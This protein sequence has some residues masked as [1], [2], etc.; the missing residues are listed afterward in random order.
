MQCLCFPLELFIKICVQMLI[1]VAPPKGWVYISIYL[2]ELQSGAIACTEVSISFCL[3]S[4]FVFPGRQSETRRTSAEFRRAELPCPGS[5]TCPFSWKLNSQMGARKLVLPLLSVASLLHIAATLRISAFNIQA[6]GD[7]KLSNE[8]AADIIINI[9]SRYDIALVQEVRDSDLSAVTKLMDQLNSMTMDAYSY[10]RS[11]PLGR[12]SYKE[13]Y[14][15]IYRKEVVSVVDRYQYEDPEDIFSR[16]PFIMKFSSP[17]LK[18][19]EFVLVPLHTCPH[20]AVTEID[21]LYDVYLDVIDK[22]ETDDIM[23]LGDFNADCS[24]VKEGDWEHI[25]LRTSE[26]FKWLIP[27]DADTT[28]G[29]SDCAYDRIV[30]CGS[31]LRKSI[32]PKSATVYNFQ[33]AFKLE[34]AEALAVS[35]H[36]PVELTLKTH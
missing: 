16:E 5:Q 24:Y 28:V 32:V 23:F 3:T 20:T 13:M 14:L 18:V 19:K 15:F 34:Q 21:A 33:R 27:D 36:F 4:L 25:R 22:W 10:E 9:L 11:K 1:T 26:V 31:K 17:Y 35:D 29:K 6:F 12:E 8:T 2:K 30:V 7:S